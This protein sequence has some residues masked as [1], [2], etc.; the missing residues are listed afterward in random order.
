LPYAFASH[1][2]PDSLHEALGIYR[3]EFQPSA[4]LEQPHAMVAANLFLAESDAEADFLF[5]GLQQQFLNLIRGQP[6]RIPP[7]V[8]S[9]DGRWT[10]PEQ[11][12]VERMTRCSL[13]GGP[14]RVRGQ[15]ESFLEETRADELI[16]T[17]MMH[18][19]TARV[20]AFERFAPLFD[21]LF[22]SRAT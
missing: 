8:E 22:A 15:L 21:E 4:Q 17:A 16:V 10:R 6:G 20:K 7:P 12:Q 19:A 9:M 5:T 13:V 1:F 11:A 14:E 3:D 18:D 2:A